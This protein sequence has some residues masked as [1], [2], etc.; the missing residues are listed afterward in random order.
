MPGLGRF[1]GE[2]KGYPLQFSGLENPMESRGCKE[3][4]TTEQ[5]SLSSSILLPLARKTAII[6]KTVLPSLTGELRQ[7]TI[8]VR[9]F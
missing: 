3:S 6:S 1:P 4:D 2:G 9:I 7:A 8:Y 5:L